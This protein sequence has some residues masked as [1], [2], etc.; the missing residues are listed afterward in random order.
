MVGGQADIGLLL[1]IGAVDEGRGKQEERV[2]TQHRCRREEGKE[3]KKQR[4]GKAEGSRERRV[5]SRT[6]DV[7]CSTKQIKEK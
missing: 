1:A 2:R 7:D 3:E 6:E 5:C 4:E